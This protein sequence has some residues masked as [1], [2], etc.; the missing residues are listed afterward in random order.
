MKTLLTLILFLIC[1]VEI[2]QSFVGKWGKL[3]NADENIRP[4]IIHNDSLDNIKEE[5][6]IDVYPSASLLR[7]W[8]AYQQECW[9]DSICSMPYAM[10]KLDSTYVGEI[11]DSAKI[12]FFIYENGWE[13]FYRLING[14]DRY[15][16]EQPTF[17]GF[18]QYLERRLK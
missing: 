6:W 9:N 17:E 13:Y 2:G 3:T 7:L 5:E 4:S 12:S 11:A 14:C 1:Q 8:K 18:M 15:S 16:H 10:A